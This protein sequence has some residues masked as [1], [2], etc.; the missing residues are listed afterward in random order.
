MIKIDVTQ[1]PKAL[2]GKEFTGDDGKPQLLRD[3]LI[4]VLAQVNPQKKM[5]GKKK[6]EYGKLAERIYENDE[7]E[8]TS[9][10]Q[11][12]LKT[13]I[14]DGYANTVL[15]MRCCEMLDPPVEEKVE[16]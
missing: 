4:T 2:G 10:Q 6:I 11:T 7:V 13:L 12:E 14:G 3:I 15:V 5:S 16:A 8:L 1:V 9:E